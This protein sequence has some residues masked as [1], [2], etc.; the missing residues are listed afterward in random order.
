MLPEFEKS[1]H[2]TIREISDN[3]WEAYKEYYKS[4]SS[5]CHFSGYFH[6]K[7]IDA[8]ETGINFF[9]DAFK[10]GNFHLFGLFHKDTMIGQTSI[11]FIDNDEYPNTA[12]LAGSE[13]TDEYRGLALV[14]KFYDFRMR[15][16]KDTE[17]SGAITMSISPENS[18]SHKAAARNG[19]TKTGK[20]T[21]YG[22]DVLAIPNPLAS[23]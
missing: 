18:N 20:T 23:P 5:P 2:I 1:S 22:Q 17:F 19:F 13:I 9:K 3:D 21:Q 16:L 4:L 11:T 12:Y 14:D 15:Y 7:D 10:E 8:P 6:D